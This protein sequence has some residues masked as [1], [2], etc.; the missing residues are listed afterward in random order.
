IDNYK[1]CE[2]IKKILNNIQFSISMKPM[3]SSDQVLKL[4]EIHQ[5]A[6]ELS[7]PDKILNEIKKGESKSREFKST[8]SLD[9]KTNKKENY[10]IESSVKSIAGFLNAEGGNLYIGVD[11]GGKIL[12]LECE[13]GENKIVKNIDKYMLM[14][15]DVVKHRLGS[16]H[17]KDI[18]IR[19]YDIQNKTIVAIHCSKSK[20]QVFYNKSDLYVRFGP[21]TEK[22]VGPELIQYS[23]ERFKMN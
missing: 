8:F 3:T 12:G 6:L 1:K 18:D 11:D 9:L 16:N 2:E 14:I 5:A 15:K 17:L 7:E 23:N 20:T 4:N 10:I 22:L 13:I 21:S 19:N